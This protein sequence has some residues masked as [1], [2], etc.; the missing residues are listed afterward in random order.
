M[1]GPVQF[2]PRLKA[3]AAYLRHAQHLPTARLRAL[4]AVVVWHR[5]L[6]A[7]RA[8]EKTRLER[9]PSAMQPLQVA[10]DA[11]L[12][13]RTEALNR[14][15]YDGM[16]D[17]TAWQTQT[18]LLHSG[19]GRGRADETGPSQRAR[20]SALAGMALLNR[21]SG[22]YR[23]P[24]RVWGGRASVRTIPCM[25][26]VTATRHNP[27]IRDFHT[28][29]CRRGKPRKVA[30]VAAMRKL[31]FTLNAVIRD[32]QPN[33]MSMAGEACLS[34]QSLNR[35]PTSYMLCYINITE[36]SVALGASP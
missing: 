6:A 4:R 20:D 22:P 15:L 26:T 35:Q 13:G 21:D 30:L 7:M 3:L 1:A 29:L 14:E 5:Q 9:V 10:P 32:Q 25:T 24:R 28:R 18:E 33:C 34:T 36:P 31:L 27:A 19:P 23:G 8:Q 17:H 12:H 16:Q 2:G 11:R